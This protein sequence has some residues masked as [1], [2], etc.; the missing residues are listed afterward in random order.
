MILEYLDKHAAEVLDYVVDMARWLAPGE[1]I[2]SASATTRPAQLVAQ[3]VTF[4]PSQVVVRLSGGGPNTRH[5]VEV[6]ATTTAGQV[7]VVTF[8]IRSHGTGLVQRPIVSVSAGIVTYPDNDPITMTVADIRVVAS[9]GEAETQT[10][11]VSVQDITVQANVGE[12]GTDPGDGG[13][14]DPEPG[15]FKPLST[16]GA[17]IVDSDGATVQLRS[18][19][20]FGAESTN[21]VPHGIW[22]RSYLDILDQIAGWGFNCLRI[23]FSGDTFRGGMVVN[24]IDTSKEDNH[25]FIASGDPTQPST[26]VFKSAMECMSIIVSAAAERGLYVVFDHHRR[27]AGSGA[28]GSPTDNANGYTFSDF[29][30]DWDRVV[31]AFASAPNVI[32]ADI[33]NEP[34]D[35]TWDSWA[36]IVELL[37]DSTLHPVAPHWLIFVEGVGTYNGNSYWWGGALQGVAD[38]P[39][40]LTIPNKLVYSPHEYGQ[41]VGSQPWLATDS[42]AVTNYP[43]NLPAVFRNAWGYI[44]EQGIAPI[45][46][47][48]FGGKFG[49]NGD[50]TT[51]PNGTQETQWCEQVVAYIQAHGLSF[52]YWSFNP[53]SGDTGGLVKD[54]WITPQ[55]HKLDIIA[56]LL[57]GAG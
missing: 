40:Q 48:E 10:V 19:N 1:T 53:N 54:D 24:G 11:M 9:I 7:K 16:S 50:G 32:G 18:V 27:T 22:Q 47:G 43:D 2:I 29:A 49:L 38:R 45:W 13:G 51:A 35:L 26:V 41:S 39:V 5:T 55:Q 12:T 34:H 21:Y 52:A 31:R 4:T 36:G 37:V 25:I 57:G 30:N 33:H 6:K 46:I 3:R 14:T 23:P 28:D 42:Q 44:A 8:G 17:K 15:V 20:W 56:P